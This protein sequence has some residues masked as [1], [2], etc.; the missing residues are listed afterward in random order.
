MYWACA[1]TEVPFF[2]MESVWRT[3]IQFRPWRPNVQTLIRL[4]VGISTLYGFLSFYEMNSYMPWH[5]Q[6]LKALMMTLEG[7]SGL[8]LA[9]LEIRSRW[10]FLIV[11]L[12]IPSGVGA[13]LLFWRKNLFTMIVA[14]SILS[15]LLWN[16]VRGKPLDTEP[17]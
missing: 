4:I 3:N 6:I 16:V 7:H 15:W 2:M 1:L 9:T 13:Y 14:A 5:R 17:V 8:W 10:R 11:L 12:L